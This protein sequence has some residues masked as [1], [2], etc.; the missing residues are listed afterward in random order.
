MRFIFTAVSIVILAAAGCSHVRGI[1]SSQSIAMLKA[2]PDIA[3]AQPVFYFCAMGASAEPFLLRKLSDTDPVVRRNAV[4]MLG[5]WLITPQAI[6]SFTALYFKEPDVMIRKS[7]LD[8]LL[9]LI[10]SPDRA[11]AFIH[12]AIQKEQNSKLNTYAQVMMEGFDRERGAFLAVLGTI[13]PDAGKF[14]KAYAPIYLSAS[15]GA[16]IQGRDLDWL[17]RFSSPVDENALKA[18]RI[19]VLKGKSEEA[20]FN[21]QKINSTILFHRYEGLIQK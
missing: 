9:I 6:E 20:L 2:D 21:Y 19:K 11:K 3:Y 10:P 7:I 5:K 13:T 14:K 15:Q 18:L 1:D 8:T 16:V 17:L 12:E 4:H